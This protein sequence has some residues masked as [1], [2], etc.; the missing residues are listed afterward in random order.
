MAK[1]S[2]GRTHIPYR[3]P[4]QAI[5]ENHKTPSHDDGE[6]AMSGRP[7]GDM[8]EMAETHGL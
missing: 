5:V 7:H 8:E 3:F 6:R 4:K 1:V 2:L